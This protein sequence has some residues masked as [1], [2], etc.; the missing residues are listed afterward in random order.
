MRK[1]HRLSAAQEQRNTTLVTTATVARRC[2][3]SILNSHYDVGLKGESRRRRDCKMVAVS[4]CRFEC[5]TEEAQ[6]WFELRRFRTRAKGRPFWCEGHMMRRSTEQSV[7]GLIDR[8]SQYSSRDFNARTSQ[9]TDMAGRLKLECLLLRGCQLPLA[10]DPHLEGHPSGLSK[11]A[12]F[13]TIW[14]LS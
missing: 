11:R 9:M 6:L 5:H 2:K 12:R 14:S 13:Q 1:R 3:G 10:V 4:T 7:V 8:S